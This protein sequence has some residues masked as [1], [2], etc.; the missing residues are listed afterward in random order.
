MNKRAIA[1]LGGVFILIVAT[2]GV[3]IYLRSRNTATT[4]QDQP[5]TPDVVVEDPT[6]EDPTD[7]PN[8]DDPQT[9][10][11]NQA[12]KLTD[13]G[14]LS[15]ALYFSGD[16]IAYFN[17]SGEL[18]R[19][20]MSIS[21]KTVLL[22]NKTKLSV[23][24]KPGIS[25]ILWPKV[26]SSY[27]TE[28]GT[29]TIKQ[30]SYYNPSSGQYVDLPGQVKSLSWMPNGDKIMF[31]W[32]G[33]DGMASLNIS[34]PDTTGYQML[35]DLYEP[36]N[37]IS[38]SPDGQLVLFYR[39]QTSD[40]TK[41]TINSVSPDGKVFNTIIREGYNKGVLWSPDSKKFLFRKLDP[42]SGKF[43]LW[44]A[45]LSTGDVRNLN[46]ATSETKAVW[47][48]D[49]Q[50]IVVAVP[51]SGTVGE[52]ITSDTF[53]KLDI[54]TNARTEFGPGIAVDARELF[55]SLDNNTLFFKNAQD[56]ALYYLPL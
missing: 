29:G 37:V 14:V 40:M 55:L 2:L 15:P 3:I 22:S 17:T 13:E 4:V 44:F 21:D 30:W 26:G 6:T 33:N 8:P 46:I 42:S 11:T 39:T 38:V 25:T 10:S 53:Y 1:I 52:G 36:D 35:T 32:V 23:P 41:N 45:D 48:K 20:S 51:T 47:T 27:I 50:S 19:T 12:T 49:G 28:S 9:P 18:F 31:V 24:Q 7:N 34:N 56:N 43:N 5:T 16:G 54:Y